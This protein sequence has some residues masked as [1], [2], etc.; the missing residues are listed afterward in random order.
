MKTKDGREYVI[1]EDGTMWLQDKDKQGF[2]A[3]GRAGRSFGEM[4]LDAASKDEN[5]RAAIE[6]HDPDVVK[7]I[8]CHSCTCYNP[9]GSMDGYGTCRIFG[10]LM[11]DSEYCCYGKERTDADL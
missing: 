4:L 6:G 7:I 1:T 10:R 11:K 3:Q 5:A 9:H 2:T 8:R